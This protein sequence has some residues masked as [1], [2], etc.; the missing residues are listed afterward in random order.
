MISSIHHTGISVSDL[1]A[2]KAFYRDLLGMEVVREVK[3]VGEAFEKISG[4]PGADVDV[5]ILQKGSTAIELLHYLSPQGGPNP[6]TRQCERGIVH[7]AFTVEDADAAYEM[8]SKRGVR[9]ISRPGHPREGG[10]KICYCYGP[11]DEVL[12]LMQLPK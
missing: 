2:S 9:I 6:H 4:I 10:P 7:V 11:D 1:E 8:L 12:E 5:C 3:L